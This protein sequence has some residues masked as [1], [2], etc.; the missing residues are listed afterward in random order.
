MMILI[1][2]KYY[3]RLTIITFHLMSKFIV[4]LEK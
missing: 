1:T 2:I 4:I 3:I